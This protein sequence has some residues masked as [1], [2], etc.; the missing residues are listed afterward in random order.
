M[1][2]KTLT[3]KIRGII[4][5]KPSNW[6]RDANFYDANKDWMD[7]SALIAIKILRT[8]RNQSLSQKD[9]ADSIGVTPQYIN[10][11]SKGRENL[12]L[13]TICKIEKSLSIT[14]ISVP[15]YQS[16]QVIADSFIIFPQTISRTNSLPLGTDKLDYGSESNYTNEEE[17]LAA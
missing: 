5:E 1:T 2:A 8:L 9:L 12:S 16:T 6:L 10:K 4:S 13:T 3:N 17:H 7:K 14:L 11:V 15:S